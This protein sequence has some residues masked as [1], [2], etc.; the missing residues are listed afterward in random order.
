MKIQLVSLFLGVSFAFTNTMCASEEALR[1]DYVVVGMGAAGA[2]I[3]KILSDN[4]K[5]SVIGLEAGAN[6]DNHE[7]IKNPIYSMTLEEDFFPQYFYQLQQIVQE[8]APE[9]AFNYTT[10]RLFGGGSSVNGMQYVQGSPALYKEWEYLLGASWSVNK[11]RDT[12]KALEHFF[13]E[14]PNHASRGYHGAVNIR[15]APKSPTAMARKFVDAVSQ[16]TSYPQIMDYNDPYTPI[17]PFTQWQ[18]FQ[19]PNKTRESSSTAYLK[20]ILNDKFHGMHSRQLRVLE[21]ATVLRVIFEGDTAVGV[22]YLC[23]GKCGTAYANKKVILSAGVYSPWLLQLSGIGPKDVLEKAGVEVIYD[24]PNVGKNLINHFISMAVFQANPKDRGLRKNDPEALYTGG[25]FLPDPTPPV[26]SNRRGVQMIGMS[27]GPGNFIL[28]SIAVQPK[29]RGSLVIQS[30][31]PLQVPLVDDG[32]FMHPADLITYK[33]IYKI[34][35]K[36]IAEKLNAIDSQ[37]V[38]VAPSL[39]VIEDDQALEDYIVN[40]IEHTHHWAGTCRMAPLNKGGV[41]DENG[42]VYGVRNLIVADDSIAPFI[43]DGN[44]AACAFMIGR[45]IAKELQQ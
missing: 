4:Q 12:F 22:E 20:D 37:Y 6:C 11:I 34:Y 41:V 39:S 1:A 9:V 27:A 44:T 32:A 16:A 5:V 31:D 3:A 35:I 25:A 15:Q 30:A 38:L 36:D 26:K 42:H 10:G 14:T 33:N 18:L 17:G 13:G 2:G 40:T 43:P 29:S 45:K 28:A 19:N 23:N 21:R 24:N 7:E 8:N